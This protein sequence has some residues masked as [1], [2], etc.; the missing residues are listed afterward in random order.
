MQ[1]DKSATKIR[2][3]VKKFAEALAKLEKPALISHIGPDGDAIGSQIA[4]YFWFKN[5][6]IEP[7]MF[8]DD[9]VPDNLT[10]LSGQEKIRRPAKEL[11]DECDAI[12]FIDGNDPL[13]FGNMAEYFSKTGKP[14]CLID[15]HLDPPEGMFSEMLWDSGAS[16]T[17]YLV[18]TLFEETGPEAISKEA[19][20]ALYTGIVTDTGSFR[21]DTVTE[22]THF[23]VGNIIKYGGI[24]P[25]EI[26]SR[27]YDDRTLS[28][29]HLLGT[30]LK[31]IRLFCNEKVAVMEVT[32]KL[33]S[34]NGCSQDDLEGFVNY[35]LSIRGVV[36]SV[37]FYEREGRVKI[38]LRGKSLV[39]LNHVA[40][41]FDGG[42]H[43]NAA[44]AWHP[45]PVEKAVKDLIAEISGLLS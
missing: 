22:A 33:M 37:L 9:P 42:G 29:Y 16:S 6:G 27:I 1:E 45:G 39:D 44:G 13:R 28:E 10:W 32:E 18:Y 43:F 4:L 36:V 21:F 26:Y 31:G 19:A 7:L 30:T 24:R 17:A 34:E 23:A 3:M 2:K 41:Q 40:R 12:L 14:L 11:L 20:E 38:S 5:R 15:H 8:N 25:G 35:P